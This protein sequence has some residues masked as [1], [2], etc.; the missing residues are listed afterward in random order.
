MSS[1]SPEDA[2]VRCAE[3]KRVLS[4]GEER[5]ETD[6][7]AIFC[8]TCYEHLAAQVR[9]VVEAQSADINLWVPKTPYHAAR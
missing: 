5:V 3:C 9:R 8:P 7:G 4:D 2:Q 6:D 1:E